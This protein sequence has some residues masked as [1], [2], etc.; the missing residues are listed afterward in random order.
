MQTDGHPPTVRS[1]HATHN[2]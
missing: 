1:V 2:H